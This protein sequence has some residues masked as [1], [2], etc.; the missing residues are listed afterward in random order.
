MGLLLLPLLVLKE[1]HSLFSHFSFLLS[2]CF[3]AHCLI[4]STEHKSKCT[5]ERKR[6][7]VYNQRQILRSKC[8]TYKLSF[9]FTI[10]RKT[11]S[12]VKSYV[13]RSLTSY[14]LPPYSFRL[15]P[16][17]SA[18][19]FRGKINLSACVFQRET[20]APHLP[21]SLLPAPCSLLP[22]P[23]SCVKCHKWQYTSVVS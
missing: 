14:W 20:S 3:V 10:H 7:T 13:T 19:P 2:F 1:V 5:A 11:K 23:C 21:T 4:D 17:S 22:T 6:E 9:T 18:H 15:P 16:A 12:F 8:T